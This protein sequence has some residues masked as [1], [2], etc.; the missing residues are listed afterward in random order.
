MNILSNPTWINSFIYKYE[1]FED[2]P[3]SLFNEINKDLDKQQRI[4][5][6]A[7]IIISAWNEEINIL[8]CIASLAKLKTNIPFEIIIVNNNSTDNTQKTIDNLHVRS[9]FQPI[10]GW[11]PARQL[12]Q[13]NAL[14]E[15]ILLADADCI[16]PQYW[17]DNMVSALTKEDVVCAYGRYS[18]IGNS[19]FP[20]WKLF[21]LERMKDMIAEV[22]QFKRPYLNAYGINMGYKKKYGLK[23]GYAM[24]KIRGDE[25]RLCFDMMQYG[26]IKQV[27]SNKACCWTGPRTLQQDGSFGKAL[28]NRI[29]KELKRLFSMFISH[30]PHDTKTSSN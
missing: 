16:Y 8:T 10:Q 26:K 6:V 13:E 22:R 7:S 4:N 9:L 3:A 12:G 21:L 23:A 11:G 18:F 20:R 19:E 15:Y 30:P 25:G 27:K 2:I 17:L 5:P 1:R 14:G 24:Y 28:S 29:N